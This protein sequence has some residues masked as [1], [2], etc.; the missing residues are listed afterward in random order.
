MKQDVV[1]F[2]H[3]RQNAIKA[4]DDDCI[5]KCIRMTITPKNIVDIFSIKKVCF[6]ANKTFGVFYSDFLKVKSFLK[7][8]FDIDIKNDYT[9]F[10]DD[11]IIKEF[12]K[13]RDIIRYFQKISMNQDEINQRIKRETQINMNVRRREI[14]YS[15]LNFSHLKNKNILCV[16]TEVQT[17]DLHI[18]EL[19]LT[20]SS[21]GKVE[22]RHFLIKEYKDLKADRKNYQDNFNFGKS[23]IVSIEEMKSILFEYFEKSDLFMAHSI[24]SENH[25]LK[26]IG[27]YLVDYIDEFIDT[28]SMHKEMYEE[29]NPISL[30]NL[31]KELKI[32]FSF[33][34]NSGNDAYYTWQCFINM[35]TIKNNKFKNR[36]FFRKDTRKILSGI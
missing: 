9:P 27:I 4:V 33:L 16:D 13:G 2:S 29:D 14:D 15:H 5:L 34:H 19:G 26:Q 20:F 23:E 1:P 35:L 17:V 28:Q 21:K 18:T 32:P 10:P 22:T 25:Y 3:I 24:H 8:Q 7:E 31:L 6:Y 11:Y 36:Q 30:E 12:D